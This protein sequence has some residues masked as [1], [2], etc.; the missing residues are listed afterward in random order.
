MR[1]RWSTREAGPE[2]ELLVADLLAWTPA[3]RWD[4]W[5]DRAV[6]H[7][8]TEPADQRRYADLVAAAVAP[9]G[10]AVIGTFAPDGPTTCSGL[11]TA[12]HTAASIASAIGEPFVLEH[13]ETEH[14][15]TPWGADQHFT[16]AV[17]RRRPA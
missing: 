17:L 6:F 9:G 2:P 5:H 12:R 16:W 13:G 7:F 8:L 10:V 3:R 4:L 11:P 15:R 1:K 14:H